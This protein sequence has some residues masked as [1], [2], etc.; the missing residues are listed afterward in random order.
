MLNDEVVSSERA[1]SSLTNPVRAVEI[2][3]TPVVRLQTLDL[4]RHVA[5]A[6]DGT[7]YVVATFDDNRLGRGYITAI[8]PQQNDYLT[9]I[10]LVIREI[11]SKTIE[12]AIQ[13]HISVVQTIQQGKLNSLIK[14]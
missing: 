4:A 10:R 5:I 13:Q 1:V 9:L 6:P 12:Q 11:R 14:A 2:P 7:R 8:Y 3:N